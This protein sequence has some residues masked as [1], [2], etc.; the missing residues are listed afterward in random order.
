MP[1]K[2]VLSGV[3]GVFDRIVV[4]P[5]AAADEISERI[6]SVFRRSAEL[7][8]EQIAVETAD[9]RVRLSGTV[10]SWAEREAAGRAAWAAPGVLQVE[11][12]I[13]VST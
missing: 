6:L 3:R 10:Q 8:A 9:G 7:D 4:R 1:N 12:E 2:S 5:E 11:N 13:S